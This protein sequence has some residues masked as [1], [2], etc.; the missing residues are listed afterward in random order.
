MTALAK[1]TEKEE[2]VMTIF[3]HHGPLAI[4]EVVALYPEPRP[5]FNTVSTFVHI[6]ERKGYLSRHK[7]GS[8]LIYSPAIAMEDYS[9][10]TLKGVINKFF[11]NSYLNVVSA[12]IK[13][14]SISVDELKE[15]IKIVEQSDNT[16]Q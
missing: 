11:D 4:R 15:L 7:E 2:E 3:W 9:R 6:L 12:L 14:D 8:S 5:H 1:L 13:S 10:L 16:P